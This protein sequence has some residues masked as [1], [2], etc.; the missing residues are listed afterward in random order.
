MEL[1]ASP[2]LSGLLDDKRAAW[3]WS[4]DG[5]RILWANAAGAAFFSVRDTSGL[6]RLSGLARSPARPHIARIATSGSTDKTS[7]DR[8]RFYRGLRVLLLTCQCQ[9]LILPNGNDA[10]LIVCGDKGLALTEPPFSAFLEFLAGND[11]SIF[12][13]D[14]RG[15]IGEQTGT[16]ADVPDNLML[17]DGRNYTFGSVRAGDTHHEAIAARID[18]ARKIVVVENT[19][20]D[21]APAPIETERTETGTAPVSETPEEKNNVVSTAGNSTTNP[22]SETAGGSEPH[23][24]T[25]AEED[26]DI[27]DATAQLAAVANSPITAEVDDTVEAVDNVLPEPDQPTDNGRLWGRAQDFN[28]EDTMDELEIENDPID[29]NSE[30]ADASKDQESGIGN[31]APANDTE[32]DNSVSVS[33]EMASAEADEVSGFAFTAR[34]RPVRFAWKMDIEQRFSFIS[35]EFGTTLGPSAADIVGKTWAEVADAL[36]IDGNGV[37]AKALDR[38][39]TW[40]GKTV[41]WPVEGQALRVPV[42]MAALPAFDRERVFEGYRGFGVCR[43]ADVVDDPNGLLLPVTTLPTEHAVPAVEVCGQDSD[44]DLTETSLETVAKSADAERS[45]VMSETAS[46]ADTTAAK[47]DATDD[48]DSLQSDDD[49][50][51]A[52][53]DDTGPTTKVTAEQ[54]ADAQSFLSAGPDI[55]RTETGEAEAD[56]ADVVEPESQ[57]FGDLLIDTVSADEDP[58]DTR[59]TLLDISLAKDTGHPGMIAQEVTT[60]ESIDMDPGVLDPET[61]DVVNVAPIEPFAS[62]AETISLSIEN[63]EPEP[64]VPPVSPPPKLD[65]QEEL[66]LTGISGSAPL[67]PAEIES[68]VKTLAKS[69]GKKPAGTGTFVPE[70]SNDAAGAPTTSTE[71]AAT[72]NETEATADVEPASVDKESDATASAADTLSDPI[73]P[74]DSGADERDFFEETAAFKNVELELE[75]SGSAAVETGSTAHLSLVDNSTS[76]PERPQHPAT[77]PGNGDSSDDKIIRLA[78][79]KPRLVPVDTSRLSKPERE[80]FRK[81]AEALGARLEGDFDD[82]DPP[83]ADEAIEAPVQAPSVRDTGPIDPRLLDRLPIGIAIAHDRDVLYANDTLLALL[84]YSSLDTLSEAGGLEAVFAE[85]AEED[86]PDADGIE[87]TV[88]GTLKVRLAEGG[89]RAVDARMH[90]VPWNGH[91]GLMISIT[92]RTTQTA[93]PTQIPSQTA[94]IVPFA[95]AESPELVKALTLIEEMDTI[96]ETATDGVLVLNDRGTITKVNRSAEALFAAGR[97]DM[98]GAPLNDYLAPESHRAAADYLDGLARNGVASILNDGREVLGRVSSGGLIP[99]FMTIGRIATNAD[100]PKFCAVLR[101]ITHWKTAEEELTQAKRQAENANSQKSDFLAKISHEIRTPLNAIIGFSEVMIEERFGSIGNDR[102]QEYLKDIRTSGSHIM[103]LINDLLDLSKVEAGKLDLHFSA[104]SANEVI[105]ECVALMQ[106]QANRDR[107]IIRASLPDSV[108][109]I[110]ADPRSMRQIVLNLLSNAIKFNKSGGQ[111]IVSTALEDT[112]EVVFRVRDTGT[113]MSAKQLAAAL[114][115]FRQ[116]H[117]ARHGGGTGLGLPLTKALVEANRATFH[118]DSTPEQGTLVEIRFPSQR[119]LSE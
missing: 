97:L 26:R 6:S 55:D 34:R 32:A 95:E 104:V 89:V 118:I 107:V 58:N 112:G 14:P 3:V 86:I 85:D 10:A 54:E 16:L 111:V 20:M 66:Q 25:V 63:I 47:D 114:E 11:R 119:V 109:S 59:D 82:D 116:V 50:I 76:A 117:T 68:A 33:T 44:Q 31:S 30:V 105:N 43:T 77:I 70:A 79:H 67:K 98:E 110:V 84:G 13:F 8:L 40:S 75:K 108:P 64:D 15:E 49:Q 100:E 102:Y 24:T 92:E 73:V 113:G 19:P 38:R 93:V 51:V 29:Q 28:D 94:T 61:L 41:H 96:L 52:T 115:P 45:V 60:S 36:N 62:T 80:A 99:L 37:I 72:L 69:Y 7:I 74:L 53:S 78:G 18:V 65:Q 2:A 106:P 46:E 48:N 4:A 23:A 35:E 56:E 42:D 12:I 88:D 1:C 9:R 103:S 57:E 81:I 87:G 71:D 5:A 17:P 39:D 22:A 101:D 27:L 90:S 83:G 91:R 21:D